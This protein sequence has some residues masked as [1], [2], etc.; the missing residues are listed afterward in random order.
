MSYSKV[1]K[2]SIDLPIEDLSLKHLAMDSS[3]TKHMLRTPTKQSIKI[4]KLIHW[5]DLAL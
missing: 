4:S 1:L 2:F 5:E 3:N